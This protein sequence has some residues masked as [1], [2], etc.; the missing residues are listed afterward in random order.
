MMFMHTCCFPDCFHQYHFHGMFVTGENLPQSSPGIFFLG[1]NF[2]RAKKTHQPLSP[3]SKLKNK[4]NKT[5][6]TFPQKIVVCSSN[7]KHA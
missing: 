4:T 2:L 1:F 6:V 3:V 5:Q 7:P